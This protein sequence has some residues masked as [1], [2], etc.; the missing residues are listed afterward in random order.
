[1]AV[2]LAVKYETA[3]LRFNLSFLTERVPVFKAMTACHDW[4]PRG[5]PLIGEISRQSPISWDSWINLREENQYF[6]KEMVTWGVIFGTLPH[7]ACVTL[8]RYTIH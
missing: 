1:M 8:K 6:E 4:N 5:L 7:G 2:V 3:R